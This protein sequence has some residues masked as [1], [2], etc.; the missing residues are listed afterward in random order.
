MPPATRRSPAR[1]APVVRKPL[2][3]RREDLVEAALRVLVRDGVAAATTRAIVA[4]AGASLSAFH[5]CFDS[6]EELLVLAAERITDRTVDHV[7]EGFSAD[8]D[9]RTVV[10]GA[11]TALWER[12]E[13]DPHRELIGYELSHHARHRPELRPAVARLFRH[14]LDVHEQFLADGAAA[15]GFTWT[16]PVPVLARLINSTLDGLALTWLVDRDG[17][18]AREVIGALADALLAAARPA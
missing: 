10:V 16:T 15:A 6:R 1:R 7:R 5:Y 18:A 9:L 13:A 17:E 3:D 2:A 11:L 12:L 4:E 14:Y 8:G